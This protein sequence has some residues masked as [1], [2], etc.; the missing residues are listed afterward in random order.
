MSAAALPASGDDARMS[1]M[2]HL[3]ELRNRLIKVAVAV[4]IGMVIGFF[5]YDRIFNL[6]IDPYVRAA[7]DDSITDGRL[8]AV[9]PLEGFAVRMKLSAYAGIFLAMP[10]IL[11]QI[12]QFITPGLYAHEKRYAVPFLASALTL[13]LLGASLAYYTLPQALTFLQDIGGD[14][15]VTAYAP[16]KYFTLIT[17]M[18]LAFGVGFE[19][20]ILLVFLEL[21]GIVSPAQLRHVRR[22]AIV[23]IAVVVAV[24]T[25]SGDPISM[26]M[27]SVPMII[28]YE[29]AILIGVVIERRR[30]RTSPA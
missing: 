20:P 14:N 10:I 9:D 28:F 26:L 1:L 23:G 19:F 24:I 30:A 8:L 18:M 22:Y 21:A 17:Y 29:V 7:G 5:L 16:G 13:F 4:V 12:W 15:I 2:E 6:L 25:P 27:L 11:W 3:T